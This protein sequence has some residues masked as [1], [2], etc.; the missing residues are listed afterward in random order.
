MEIRMKKH[1][2]DQ[3]NTPGKIALTVVFAVISVIWMMPII[4]VLYN[5]LKNNGAINTALF[6]LPDSQ[7][8]VGFNNY[9]NGMTFGNY[10]FLKSALYSAVITLFSTI[11]IL[12]MTSMAA[13]YIARVDSKACRVIY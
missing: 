11:L 8:Y 1:D 13:W 9:T 6:D 5:S 3:R 12:L 10:P 2:T 7:S 4:I